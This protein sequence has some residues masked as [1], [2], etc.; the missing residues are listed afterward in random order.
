MFIPTTTVS[1]PA[2]PPHSQKARQR[3]VSTKTLDRCQ[4]GI[5][6]KSRI[7]VCIGPREQVKC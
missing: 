5:I 7:I 6:D 2:R 3:G 4:D 1:E